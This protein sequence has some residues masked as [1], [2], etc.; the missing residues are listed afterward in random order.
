MRLRVCGPGESAPGGGRRGRSI[1]GWF[2]TRLGRTFR[3]ALSTVGI[4]QA[5]KPG[6]Y[7]H[8][9]REGER[10]RRERERERAGPVARA[11]L[12]RLLAMAQDGGERE[13]STVEEAMLAV[14][15]W[16]AA[17]GLRFAAA[18]NILCVSSEPL[19]RRTVGS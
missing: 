13:L 18:Y 17:L 7:V 2:G 14:Y 8:P 1:W 4:K 10:A 12:G 16:C 11:E 15:V 6:D 5:R 19:A 9:G 3:S